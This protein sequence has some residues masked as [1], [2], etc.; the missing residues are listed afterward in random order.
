VLLV[1]DSAF[2]LN[3]EQSYLESAGYQVITAEHG[4]AAIEVL[5]RR[6]INVV[7][8]DI[9]MPYCNGY[10][11]TKIIKGH[12][13]WKHLPVMALTALSGE[14]DRRKG[15]EAGIDEYK[16]KLD[17]DDVLRALEQLILRTRRKTS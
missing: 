14:E 7:V 16:I 8:T 2:F 3:I 13:E 6:P 5:E 12:E 15:M 1:E 17:R 10:E 11:L 4:N 9:D